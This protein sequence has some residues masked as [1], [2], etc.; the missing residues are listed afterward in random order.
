MIFDNLVVAYFFGPPCKF[1]EPSF[2]K[3]TLQFK[4]ETSAAVFYKYNSNT[5]CLK[6][7]SGNE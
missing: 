4:T 1:L 2:K 5:R 6:T 7:S 3:F